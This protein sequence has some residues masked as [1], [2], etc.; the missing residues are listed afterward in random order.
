M[1]LHR[2]PETILFDSIDS[3][4]QTLQRD[5]IVAH[6]RAF[7]RE[8]IERMREDMM[9]AFWEA[10]QRPGGTVGR[11]PR[12]WYVEVHP[13]AISGFTELVAH[14]WFVGMCERVLGPEYKVVEIGFDTPFQGAKVQPWHRDFPSPPESYIEHRIRMAGGAQ[15]PFSRAAMEE[16]HLV[17]GGIPRLINTLA[18]TALIDAFGEDA[19]MIDPSRIE[20]AARE[21]RL[22]HAHG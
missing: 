15:N 10:I 1:A 8:F 18:T 9:T 2:S 14:P 13:Q 5:G 17:S 21:H 16:I 4:I 19:P 11:G 22:E 20:S 3:D 12:R 7:S 6:K